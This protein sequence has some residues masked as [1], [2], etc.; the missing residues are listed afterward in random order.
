MRK[1]R[2]LPPLALFLGAVGA[3][4]RRVE[5]AEG[6][7]SASGL[8][9]PGCGARWALVALTAALFAVLV[10]AAVL[11]ARRLQAADGFRKAFYT[12]GYPAFALMAVL[13][14]AV[15]VC[16]LIAMGSGISLMDLTGMARWVFLALLALAG[17]GMT[18]MAY[19]AYTQ[20][21]T[22][23]LKIGSVMP[24]LLYCY[25]LVALYRVNAGNPVL[26]DYC[27][28]AL[29]LACAAMGFFY[30]AGYAFERRNL[31]GSVITGP[32]SAF[33][34]L[35]AAADPWPMPL[36]A[37]LAATA[38]Y[39]TVS[40]MQFL[41]SLKDKPPAPDPEQDAEPSAEQDAKP[42]AKPDAEQ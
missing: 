30:A 21:D 8:A 38:L 40:S 18:V 23:F 37:A 20:R 10:A 15:T 11:A 32:F 2:F 36:R 5:L 3:L 7:E 41:A 6:F 29:A 4:L 12:Q 24:A 22:S 34:L 35:V 31:R 27:Y 13:G 9:R 39:L 33:L 26:A 1:I 28:G 14:L 25:W 17:L 42:D 16:A 19:S